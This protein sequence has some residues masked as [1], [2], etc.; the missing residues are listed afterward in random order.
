M[1]KVHSNW[2]Q[3]TGM[4]WDCGI[5]GQAL[6]Y[7]WLGFKPGSWVTVGCYTCCSL[8]SQWIK[9]TTTINIDQHHTLRLSI[10]DSSIGER[11]ETMV[12]WRIDWKASHLVFKCLWLC[13]DANELLIII[14]NNNKEQGRNLTFFNY[15]VT[16]NMELTITRDFAL[17]LTDKPPSNIINMSDILIFG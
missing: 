7:T 15:I 5:C 6:I 14:V 4:G 9:K 1:K 10:S 12:N 16:N 3:F 2:H 8:D 13:G 11:G 17:N